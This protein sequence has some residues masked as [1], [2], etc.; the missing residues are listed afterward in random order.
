MGIE[1]AIF[2]LL[3][4]GKLTFKDFD[5]LMLKARNKGKGWWWVMAT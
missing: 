1:I 2:I 4:I 3:A 5:A